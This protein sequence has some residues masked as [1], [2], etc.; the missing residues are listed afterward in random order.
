M[1]TSSFQFQIPQVDCDRKCLAVWH[2]GAKFSMKKYSGMPFPRPHTPLLNYKNIHKPRHEKNNLSLR[3]AWLRFTSSFPSLPIPFHFAVS[4]VWNTGISKWS[5]WHS[6]WPCT[7]SRNYSIYFLKF[8]D[9]ESEPELK[10]LSGFV[11]LQSCSRGTAFPIL[12]L[13]MASME[14]AKWL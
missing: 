14:T 5:D 12:L 7:K 4:G 11:P 9:F 6:N 1:I 10:S 2:K 13:H 8:R 3:T